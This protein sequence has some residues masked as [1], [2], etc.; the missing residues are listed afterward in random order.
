VPLGSDFIIVNN[1]GPT[2]YSVVT[3]SCAL[4]ASQ[5]LPP[6]IG[7]PIA[8]TQI[9]VLDRHLN[10]APIGVA[11]EL[12][13][14]GGG[15]AVGYHNLPALT[16]ESFIPNPIPGAASARLYKT[17]DLVRYRSDGMLDYLGRVDAQ[18]K[19]RG[20]RIEP[21][22]IEAVL[23]EH[24]DIS[25]AIV[26]V[27]TRGGE[28]DRLVAYVVPRQNPA[29]NGNGTGQSARQELTSALRTHLRAHLP[30]YMVPA[31]FVVLPQLPQTPN[32]KVDRR[33][34]PSPEMAQ[35]EHDKVY[36]APKSSLEEV[37]TGI[38]SEVLDVDGVGVDDNF[39]EIGG[40]SLL[41]ARLI[42]RVRDRLRVEV[43]LHTLFRSP[44][45]AQFAASLLASAANPAVVEKMAKLVASLSSLSDDEVKQILARS[46]AT[47]DEKVHT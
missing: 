14:G 27:A 41:A 12:Y 21:G 33:A 45:P 36:A 29:L 15:L 19:I 24:E 7:R 46:A 1:Y 6:S 35:S 23:A 25:D 38:W 20:F 17:G 31:T 39:F 30:D 10:P 8:N 43:P 32:G 13:V 2:E 34:L 47:A 3:T 11:G 37:L 28:S 5:G 26:T 42:S 9:Y 40:H 18:I 4:G 22:E 44:T 16:A